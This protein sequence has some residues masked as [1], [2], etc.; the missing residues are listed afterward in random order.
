MTTSA[1]IEQHRAPKDRSLRKP[2]S[3]VAYTAKT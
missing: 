3:F 2:R 1:K